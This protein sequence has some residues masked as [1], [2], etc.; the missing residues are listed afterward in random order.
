LPELATGSD[1]RFSR[2]LD[3]ERRPPRPPRKPV[4]GTRQLQRLVAYVH[5]DEATALRTY[6]ERRNLSESE[7][8]RRA[9]RKF[10]RI[11]D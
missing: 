10:L 2:V 9:L 8:V 7:V 3:M 1:E 4:A 6:A 5:G 11:A